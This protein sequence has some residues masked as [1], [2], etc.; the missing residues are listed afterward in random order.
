MANQ[1]AALAEETMYAESKM[2][3]DLELMDYGTLPMLTN[4]H[5]LKILTSQTPLGKSSNLKPL[6]LPASLVTK[7]PV[8][9]FKNYKAPITKTKVVRRPVYQVIIPHSPPY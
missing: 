6:F 7:T 3:L 4:N 5:S 1:S 9:P 8:G 2:N